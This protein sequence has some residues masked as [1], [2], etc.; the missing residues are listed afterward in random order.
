MGLTVDCSSNRIALRQIGLIGS[1]MDLFQMYYA[2][3]QEMY[4]PANH[5]LHGPSGTWQTGQSLA[6]ANNAEWII[7][8]WINKYKLTNCTN[9]PIEVTMYEYI[10]RRDVPGVT[11]LSGVMKPTVGVQ[12]QWSELITV[13]CNMGSSQ[14]SGLLGADHGGM[15][16]GPSGW[17]WDQVLGQ[18]K[19]FTATGLQNQAATLTYGRP[20][21]GLSIDQDFV[22]Y[23]CPTFCRRYKIVK[24]TAL[25]CLPGAECF[26]VFKQTRPKIIKWSNYAYAYSYNTVHQTNV[27]QVLEGERGYYRGLLVQIRGQVGNDKTDKDNVG[28]SLAAL[29]ILCNESVTITWNPIKIG[30]KSVKYGRTT[31]LGAEGYKGSSGL[32]AGVTT[33]PLFNPVAGVGVSSTH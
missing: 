30:A 29:N 27:T 4:G 5:M 15:A 32:P 13:D 16:F 28:T 25:K 21:D 23:R 2:Y 22:I 31:V 26:Y 11:N 19:H 24:R 33:F 3:A 20:F 8:K 6:I 1:F 14:Y 10:A 7:E 12:T 9:V 17:P 18:D